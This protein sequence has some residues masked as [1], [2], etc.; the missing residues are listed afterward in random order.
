M[1][2]ITRR[3]GAQWPR[4]QGVQRPHSA[5]NARQKYERYLTLGPRARSP[6]CR[7]G[8]GALL[9]QTVDYKT[10]ILI[11]VRANGVMIV[12]ADWPHV[13]NQAEVQKEIDTAQWLRDFRLVHADLDHSG[14]RGWRHY[15]RAIIW[16]SP[17][18]VNPTGPRHSGNIEPIIP[19]SFSSSAATHSGAVPDGDYPPIRQ[20][21]RARAVLRSRSNS[22]RYDGETS[23]RNAS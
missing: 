10:H 23:S 21:S 13:P 1:N 22:S 5:G 18:L 8:N 20:S 6:T 11:G 7:R 3:S 14:K 16:I 4:P 17:T 2:P 19:F 9:A 15:G 12:I